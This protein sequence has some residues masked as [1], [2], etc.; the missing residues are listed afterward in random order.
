MPP[1]IFYKQ[2][3]WREQEEPH[4]EQQ[5]GKQMLFH[6]LIDFDA[7]RGYVVFHLHKP[8]GDRQ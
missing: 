6:S 7:E 4:G 2:E 3:S 5:D 1:A 8:R